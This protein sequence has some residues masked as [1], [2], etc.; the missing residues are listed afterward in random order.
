M[1]GGSSLAASHCGGFSCCRMQTLGCVGFS[2]HSTQAQQLQHTDLVAP[3]HVE[4]SQTRDWT[5]VPC[6]GRRIRDHW[7]IKSKTDV[8]NQDC[9]ICDYR[10]WVDSCVTAHGSTVAS[11]RIPSEFTSIVKIFF[12]FTTAWK[13]CELTWICHLLTSHELVQKNWTERN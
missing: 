12:C 3:Q 10:I 13:F 1:S 6:I 8:L 9:K 5:H 11:L 7:T 4:S 2:C